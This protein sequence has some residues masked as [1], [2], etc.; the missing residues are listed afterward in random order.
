VAPLRIGREEKQE[1]LGLIYQAYA[2]KMGVGLLLR[3]WV[4]HTVTT[5]SA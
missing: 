1:I 4:L 3:G 2:A 5:L